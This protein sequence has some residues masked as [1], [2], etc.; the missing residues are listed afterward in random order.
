VTLSD[1]FTR[2]WHLKSSN[3]FDPLMT[4]EVT[5]YGHLLVYFNG[6]LSYWRCSGTLYNRLK[7]C[8][9]IWTVS[10]LPTS[11]TN[12]GNSRF[13]RFLPLS[14]SKVVA[15]GTGIT[16]CPL[17]PTF[18]WLDLNRFWKGFLIHI[19]W[20]MTHV[21]HICDK[22][23]VSLKCDTHGMCHNETQCETIW[24][25][26]KQ[27]FFLILIEKW[28]SCDTLWLYVTLCHFCDTKSC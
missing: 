5:V 19:W 20:L 24:Q 13:K 28:N 15:E 12:F 9:N 26:I 14:D 8:R 27:F 2:L 16:F 23:H 6:W 17:P 4:A 22:F 3:S 11:H 21:I 1:T 7:I 10:W 25:I 18:L